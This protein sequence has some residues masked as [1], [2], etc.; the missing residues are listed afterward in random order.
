VLYSNIGEGKSR[1][2]ELTGVVSSKSDSRVTENDCACFVATILQSSPDKTITPF[3]PVGKT[4]PVRHGI[5]RGTIP[6]TLYVLTLLAIA[7]ESRYIEKPC[8]A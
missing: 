8:L 3:S 6:Q 4:F 7:E 5:L 2:K 1:L